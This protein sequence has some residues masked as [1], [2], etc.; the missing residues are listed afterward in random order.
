[1]NT[2][3]ENLVSA[4]NDLRL[5]LACTRELI[6]QPKVSFGVWDAASDWQE[7][8]YRRWQ[9]ALSEM[10]SVPACCR[11]ATATA[12][13]QP[14]SHVYFFRLQQRDGQASLRQA[15]TTLREATQCR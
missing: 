5:A 11:I 2:R 7:R 10:G 12:D 9:L 8:A 15:P 4:S 6:K 14:T 3:H 1:M 13:T